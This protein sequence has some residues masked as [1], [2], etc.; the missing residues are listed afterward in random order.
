MIDFTLQLAESNEGIIN[1]PAKG[2][3]FSLDSDSEAEDNSGPMRVK[4]TQM[5]EK[6]A[7]IHALG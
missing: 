5:D 4:V 2:G 7:A 1:E 6:A 3:E